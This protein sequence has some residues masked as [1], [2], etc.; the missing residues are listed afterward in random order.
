MEH[1]W[2][3][4]C[5]E[6]PKTLLHLKFHTDC[7]AIGTLLSRRC[8]LQSPEVWNDTLSSTEVIQSTFK[9]IC[10]DMHLNVCERIWSLWHADEGLR[11][12]W[13]QTNYWQAERL[14]SAAESF[15]FLYEPSFA[16]YE[17]FPFV[18]IWW[19]SF[20]TQLTLKDEAQTALFKDPVRTAL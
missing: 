19:W 4:T 9:R 6:T 13:R 11:V 17:L 15:G 8:D 3:V 20:A 5:S 18:L 10:E 7:R 16:M 1:W 2:T 14:S 12:P